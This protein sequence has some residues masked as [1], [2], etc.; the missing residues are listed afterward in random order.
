MMPMGKPYSQ[1]H[2]LQRIQELIATA[3]A[4]YNYYLLVFAYNDIFHAMF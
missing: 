2:I 4:T 1:Q 3:G